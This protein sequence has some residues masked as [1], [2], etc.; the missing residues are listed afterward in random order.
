L[1]FNNILLCNFLFSDGKTMELDEEKCK[2]IVQVK[3]NDKIMTAK[4]RVKSMHNFF[5]LYE[6]HGNVGNC[7]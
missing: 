2:H 4:Q 1:L 5:K 6:L 3:L 7:P